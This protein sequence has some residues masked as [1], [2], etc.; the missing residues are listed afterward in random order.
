MV[1]PVCGTGVFVGGQTGFT[2]RRSTVPEI[3][4]FFLGGGTP[5]YAEATKFG[6]VTQL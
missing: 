2:S 1:T 6:T 4:F 3:R 5:I